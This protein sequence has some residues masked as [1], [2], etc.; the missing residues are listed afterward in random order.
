MSIEITE[1]IYLDSK[2]RVRNNFKLTVRRID[3]GCMIMHPDNLEQAQSI[4]K[5]LI[6]IEKELKLC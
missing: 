6:Q 3:R 5:R 4:A 2:R 1:L